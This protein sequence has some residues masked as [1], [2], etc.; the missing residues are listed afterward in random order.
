MSTRVIQ[1][2]QTQKPRC[3][4][5]AT[6]YSKVKSK[7]LCDRCADPEALSGGIDRKCGQP[8]VLTP[9]TDIETR[10]A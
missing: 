5:S 6:V 7:Y 4:R 1:L 10:R 9:V 2:C 3:G 8:E